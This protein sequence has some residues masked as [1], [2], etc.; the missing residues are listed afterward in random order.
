MEN[1]NQLPASCK[2]PYRF[3]YNTDVI[4]PYKYSYETD[5]WG[6]YNANEAE[7]TAANDHIPTIY[8]YP[9]YQIPEYKGNYSI[10][11]INTNQTEYVLE[12]AD[13]N[14]NPNVIQAGILKKIEY[15]TGGFEEFE[16][17]CN[18]FNLGVRFRQPIVKGGGIRIKS[19]KRSNGDGDILFTTY[20]YNNKGFTSGLITGLPHFAEYKEAVYCNNSYGQCDINLN[21]YTGAERAFFDTRFY[22]NSLISSGLTTRGGLVG[23]TKVT[24]ETNSGKVERHFMFPAPFGVNSY[25][26]TM[27]EQGPL[28]SIVNIYE[29]PTGSREKSNTPFAINP[30]LDFLRGELIQKYEFDISGNMKKC[31]R[32]YPLVYNFEK[33]FGYTCKL[34]DETRGTCDGLNYGDSYFAT[35][36][37]YYL[38]AR[39]HN[40]KTITTEYFEEG[41]SLVIET[42]YEFNDKGQLA[43]KTDKNQNG[44]EYSIQYLHIGDI[45]GSNP[46]ASVSDEYRSLKQ[47]QD[48]NQI[49]KPIE[50]IKQKNNKTIFASY[51]E[52]KQQEVDIEQQSPYNGIFPYPLKIHEAYFDTPSDNFSNSYSYQSGVHPDWGIPLYDI[53]IDD[54]YKEKVIIDKYDKQGNILKY[55][56]VDGNNNTICWNLSENK[57]YAVVEHPAGT[58]VLYS[59]F[60]SSDFSKYDDWEFDYNYAWE[61]FEDGYFDIGSAGFDSYNGPQA[62]RSKSVL[63][64]GTYEVSFYAFWLSSTTSK[65]TIKSNDIVL[66]VIPTEGYNWRKRTIEVTLDTPGKISFELI[67]SRID[68]LL[69]I[70][71][72]SKYSLY[73]YK[74]LV[75]LSTKTD[76]NGKTETYEY[77]EFGRLKY[78][79]D[80][81]GNILNKYDY[82]YGN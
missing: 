40:S 34:V 71:S 32:N 76:K 69:I 63:P 28:S 4:L 7:I 19:I 15:P 48:Y 25:D 9:D 11:P 70:P 22:S 24:E 2:P 52:Y 67:N 51:L 35:A 41:D 20:N 17:Q 3:E 80:H 78:V 77:D 54:L 33:H 59:S 29:T 44:D 79:K 14:T 39:V 43:S 10:F 38:T 1:S 53:K 13:R 46:G 50:V 74:P 72:G 82:N 30:N 64:A 61:Y 75:G 27:Y 12:G 47:L 55:H 58:K 60:E 45:I 37:S 6:F 36:S 18:E 42:E 26:A 49:S 16:Y 68:N 81:K 66:G 56:Q 23:Y 65:V 57:P 31:I 8:Y 5:F 62:V 21:D 73:T